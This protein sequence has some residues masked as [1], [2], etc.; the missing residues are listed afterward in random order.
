MK[1]FV[2]ENMPVRFS[3]LLAAFDI[4]NEYHAV[5]DDF[6]KGAKDPS[7]M[8]A[9]AKRGNSALISYDRRILSDNTCRKYYQ[10]GQIPLILLSN[11]WADMPI[12]MQMWKLLKVWPQVLKLIGVSALPATFEIRAK[13]PNVRRLS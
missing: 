8:E 5:I 6:G 4:S 13:G 7:I 2:D 3:K 10:D 11:A 9:L 1:F 12:E